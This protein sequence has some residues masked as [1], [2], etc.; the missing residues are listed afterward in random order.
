MQT[1]VIWWQTLEDT[2]RRGR[3]VTLWLLA[4]VEEERREMAA[5]NSLSRIAREERNPPQSTEPA[6]T[7]RNVCWLF[8]LLIF[9]IIRY[10]I[11]RC[12]NFKNITAPAMT[13]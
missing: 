2:R 4:R 3:E 6:D 12:L 1:H 5:S 13:L 10:T 9:I 8:I 7:E 11:S